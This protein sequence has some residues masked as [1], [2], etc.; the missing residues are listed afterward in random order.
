MGKMMINEKRQ[1]KRGRISLPLSINK[2]TDAPAEQ[3]E[4]HKGST[5]DLSNSGLG[6]FSDVEIRPGTVIEVECR[7]IWEAPKKFPVKWCYKMRDNFYRIGLEV[8]QN[9]T[10]KTTLRVVP[11]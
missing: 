8:N 2:Q 6:I 9:F 3:K 1:D 7:D 5:A 11:D 10:G 4:F